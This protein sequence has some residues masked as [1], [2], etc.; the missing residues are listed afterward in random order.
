MHLVSGFEGEVA[1]IATSYANEFAQTHQDK[2]GNIYLNYG[3]QE[4]KSLK[5]LL[6]AH[7]DEVDSLYKLS[8]QME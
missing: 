4:E 1:D 6:D 3:K 7:M 8:D 5:V 2:M